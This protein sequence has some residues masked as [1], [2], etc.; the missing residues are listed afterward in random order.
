MEKVKINPSQLFVFVFLFEMGSAIL[1][2]LG[3]E[4][5]Q[6][7]WLTVVL[8]LIG[9]IGLFFVYHRLFQYY[10]ELPLTGYLPKITGKFIG[11]IL[12]FCYVIYFLYIASRILRDFGELLVGTIYT[13]T[14]LFVVNSLMMITIVYA[15]YKGIEVLARAGQIYFFI[16]YLIAVIGII[17]VFIARLVHFENLF[18]VLENGWT[19][20][21]KIF[22]KQTLTFPFGE[23]ITFT[24]ILP[25]LNKPEKAKQVCLGGMILSGINIAITLVIDVSVLG[26]D[27]YIRSPFPL[28]ST[29]QKIELARFI[30]RLDVFFM[31]YLIIGGF[32][33]ASL[34]F[35]AAVAGAADVFNF[36]NQRI[37]IFPLGLIVLLASIS[38]AGNFT[39]YL[40][41]GL[42]VV[43]IYLHWPM[44]IIIPI[45][46]LIIAFFRNRKQPNQ[47]R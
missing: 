3:A 14:P 34:L 30:E 22:L 31:I 38:I 24:M 16:V 15:I 1:I 19:P 39:E 25:L 45:M 4:A 46:L 23:M 5:K 26:V 13:N 28:L 36:K 11:R 20:V 29:I 17:L 44:Q 42:E 43:P 21:L 47:R 2:G 6:D 27:L 40:S 9:G 35:Y 8:G 32:F 41:E 37:L 18:P 10:P 33:K 7:A 12:G